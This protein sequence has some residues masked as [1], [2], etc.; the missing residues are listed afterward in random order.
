M[1]LI[2]MAG[3]AFRGL[4]FAQVDYKGIEALKSCLTGFH[5]YPTNATF[6]QNRLSVFYGNLFLLFMH[7][8]ILHIFLYLSA[9]NIMYI[10]VFKTSDKLRQ[11]A[12]LRKT[13]SR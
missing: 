8:K 9:Y 13:S 4:L 11:N 10:C 5:L 12:Y 2:L 3:H 7:I 1:R 6:I